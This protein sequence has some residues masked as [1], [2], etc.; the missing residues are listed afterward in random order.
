MAEAVSSASGGVIFSKYGQPSDHAQKYE[1]LKHIGSGGFGDVIKSRHLSTNILVAIKLLRYDPTKAR[2]DAHKESWNIYKAG[3]H[4]NIALEFDSFRFS[5]THHAIAM[6]LFDMDLSHFFK[7][8]HN[9]VIP[10]MVD[11]SLQSVTGLAYLH[12][13][14]P[15]MIHL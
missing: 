4:F 13:Q 9:R 10:L 14:Q 12:T 8:R 1:L 6:E 2:D 11:V 15:P 3:N 5:P 7:P